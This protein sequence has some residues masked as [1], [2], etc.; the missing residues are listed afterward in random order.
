M[1]GHEKYCLQVD[2]GY[3]FHLLHTHLLFLCFT[4][5]HVESCNNTYDEV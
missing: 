2:T 3:N 5:V 4:N 1:N